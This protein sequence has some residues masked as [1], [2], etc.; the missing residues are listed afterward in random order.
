[1]PALRSPWACAKLPMTSSSAS[2]ASSGVESRK[3]CAAGSSFLARRCERRLTNRFSLL[4]GLLP[5]LER[6]APDL[7]EALRG[8]VVVGVLG[9]VR[10]EALV[11]ERE[12]ARA[13]RDGHG[14]LEE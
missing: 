12:G 6:E 7:D 3:A 14:A 11:V 2:C 4:A 5:D 8:G 10:R 1:M 9:A 13:S